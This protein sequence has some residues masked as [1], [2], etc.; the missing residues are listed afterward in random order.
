MVCIQS[1]CVQATSR[2]VP[3]FLPL[4]VICAVAV[5]R[6]PGGCGDDFGD[7]EHPATP[8]R[9]STAPAATTILFCTVYL[10]SVFDRPAS[11]AEQNV[12]A[13]MPDRQGSCGLKEYGDGT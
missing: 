2:V 8:T 13:R 5:G 9:T 1:S 10:D 11:G 7:D 6:L 3:A 4:M 12:S